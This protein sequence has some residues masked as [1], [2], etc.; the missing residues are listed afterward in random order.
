MSAT[1]YAAARC[2]SQE[3][4]DCHADLRT[5]VEGPTVEVRCK[6][7]Q[8]KPNARIVVMPDGKCTMYADSNQLLDRMKAIVEH[9]L[10]FKI[11]MVQL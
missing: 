7:P 1:E 5:M 8:P 2:I 6:G 10:G 11:E 3:V 4:W 9:R